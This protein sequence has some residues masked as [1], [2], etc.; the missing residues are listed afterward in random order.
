VSADVE[1]KISYL[2]KQVVRFFEEGQY[3]R[4]IDFAIRASDLAH[5]H[6]GDEHPDYAKS[7]NNLAELYVATGDYARAEPLH[8]QALEIRRTALGENHPDFAQSLNNLGHLYVEMSYYTKAEPLFKRAL[9]VRRK[10]LG[11]NYP[12]FALGLNNLAVLYQEMGDYPAA[13][14]LCEQA[15]EVYR[16][17][18]GEDHPDFA[19]ALNNLAQLYVEMGDYAAAKPLMQQAVEIDREALGEDH[20][21]YATDLNS[22]ALLYQEM[23]D[24]A[25]AE[26]LY[27]RTTEILREALGEDHP[28]YAASLNNLAL[29]YQ[30]MGD[31]ASAK[32]LM[33][34]A[35]EIDRKALGE[36]HPSYA[37][38][39]NDLAGI[40]RE[41]G[42]Y[43]EGE[44]LLREALG[45]Q[46][47]A[48]GEHHPDF[49]TTLNN[50][51][52]LQYATG[53][54]T[55]AEP[56]LRSALKIRRTV[57]GE[58]HPDFAQSLNNLAGLY[59][60]MGR[61][62]EAVRLMKGAMA[63]DDRTIG[64]IF[65]ISSENQ[66]AAYL[67]ILYGI[68]DTFLSMVV[69]YQSYSS[70]TVQAA[71]DLVLRR[72]ALGVEALGA[73][74]DAILGGQY[75]QLAEPLRELTALRR[76]IAQRTLA[77]PGSEDLET[78][79]KI[80]TELTDRKERLEQELA[81]RI[82]E[83]KL[84]RQL[85]AAD[86]QAV[87]D[88]LPER[89]V[90]IEFV[91]FEVFNFR[92]VRARSE[93]QWDPAHYL[94]F[95]LAAEEPDD[96]RMIDLGEA[97]A[98]DRMIASFRASITG[99]AER[100]Y[101]RGVELQPI[102]PSRVSVRSP[103]SVLRE[104]VFATRHAK[105][106]LPSEVSGDGAR[107]GSAL[108]QALF[109]PLLPAL[110]GRK[111]LF[112]APD[113]NLARLPFEVLPGGD[114]RYLIDEYWISYL[115]VGR[116]VLRFAT[117]SAMQPSLPL[118]TADP[119]FD[120]Q[121][122][123]GHESSAA[124]APFER[125]QGTRRE[126]ERVAALLDVVPLL[127]DGALETSI[128]S[129]RSPRILHLATH[130][131]FLPEASWV[132]NK[133]R[134][135]RRTVVKEEADGL[136]RLERVENPL[137]RSG[138]ALAGANTWLEGDT[139]PKEAEDGLLTAEDVTGMNLLGTELVVLSACETGLGEVRVGEGVYGLRRAFVL[140]GAKTLVMSLWKVP[141]QQT[142]EL[143]E[144]FYERL[145]EGQSRATALRVAQLAIKERYPDELL[146][147][148]AFIC[149]GDPGL[150]TLEKE[151]DPS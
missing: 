9:E 94:A 14:P 141:D 89:S 146:Y 56:L 57:L 66:R 36:D 104:T 85:Q 144:D 51:A 87:A 137:L 110:G 49:A 12:D 123:S 45:I 142:Q 91:R 42:D 10:A 147:W 54:F 23:G 33:L 1:Q 88:A 64:Q 108:R 100:S 119:D 90:L 24:Y 76:Q 16:K 29:L 58:N 2:N 19:T 99:E 130:G 128:K 59:V 125:L 113:G 44:P 47:S 53:R 41:M 129:S 34:G 107:L 39:L 7:L 22:L 135:E 17:T 105:P 26:P 70:D 118:V 97:E 82:P 150:L 126:G 136:I 102:E 48:L 115:G 72:K 75:P 30:E 67:A 149:Q 69:G 32:A 46:R 15:F 50:L 73:Q 83:M 120:L 93:S 145:L 60:A 139:P 52:W 8:R 71:L 103:R 31:Y 124:E 86:R 61:E 109:E 38:D 121:V 84:E 77:G 81:R 68:L 40:Y 92:A 138:L 28:N 101:E 134:P 140:A 55:E 63:I 25:R 37:T 111:R 132:S 106:T 143:M 20:P 13:K 21:G 112:I 35:R 95:V 151:D 133:C 27:K 6:L 18:L 116:D 5:R 96:V 122:A 65:A 62:V 74:R 79:Q 4:A 3:E 117:A 131:F 98:I 43:A 80:L 127:G 114:S 11:E 148:G 78:H